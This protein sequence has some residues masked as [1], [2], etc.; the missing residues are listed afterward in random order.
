MSVVLQ[1]QIFTSGNWGEASVT[2]G[3][4]ATVIEQFSFAVALAGTLASGDS[5]FLV[6]QNPSHTMLTLTCT[7]LGGADAF[8]LEDSAH[9]DFLFSN[10]QVGIGDQATVSTAGLAQYAPPPPCFALGTRIRTREGERPVEALRTGD[11]V[12]TASGNHRRVV[13]IGFR[14]VQLR[15]HPRPHDVLPVRVRAHAVAPSVPHRDLVLSPDHALFLDG[16]LMPVRYLCNG[17]TI[18]QEQSI[19]VKYFHVE[20]DRHDIVLAE[21]LPTESYL[22]TGNRNAFSNASGV[23]TLHA[24]FAGGDWAVRGCAPLVLEGPQL[25]VAKERLLARALS[26]GHLQTDDPDLRMIADR[27]TCSPERTG[28]TYQFRLPRPATT[29]R[30]ISRSAIPAEMRTATDDCRRLGVAVA[31][32][33]V[34][35]E[36][37][38]PG[39]PSQSVGWH[40]PEGDWRWTDGDATLH[41]PGAREVTLTSL[42]LVRYWQVPFEPRIRSTNY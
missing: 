4:T 38:Q 41:W 30:L 21:G 24:D 8:V 13:W 39:D 17:A 40:S 2:G 37:V 26:L 10:D 33:S 35:G 20:L 19:S 23:V 42:P 22:D 16:V 29:L 12:I 32:L 34:N 15:H 14:T 3:S 11:L 1:D 28:N 5:V 27:V 25:H 7:G 36:T 9:N 18:R 31:G 6:E